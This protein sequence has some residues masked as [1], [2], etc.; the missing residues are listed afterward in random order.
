MGEMNSQYSPNSVTPA[1]AGVQDIKMDSRL[2]GDCKDAEGRATH[3]AVAGNDG[4]AVLFVLCLALLS[5][6]TNAAEQLVTFVSCP[7]YRDTDAGR[8]SGCWLAD[9]H[10]SGKRFDIADAP[11]KPI[12]GRE[13]LI[14]GIVAGKPDT[15]GGVMLNPVRVSVLP[16]TCPS[17]ML[18]A[19]AFPG[20]A[21]VLPSTT[22]APTYAV[23]TPPAPPFSDQSYTIF[24]A[25]N[26]D[27]LMYQHSEVLLDAA[28]QYI[29]A[30]KP[31]R[32]VITAYAATKPIKVSGR[33]IV[34]SIYIAKARAA[35]IVEALTRLNVP[36]A[37]I[38]VETRGD[39]APDGELAKQGLSEAS[40]RRAVVR[41]EM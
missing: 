21:F 12:L 3:G 27:F 19:E 11:I 9:D 28:V 20:R 38:K 32:V 22:L 16:T 15:C 2:R 18:P 23:R 25:L 39:P 7:I 33:E 35:M 17:F 31:K 14:E 1:Q 13:I 30:A 29:E 26:S 6:R 10:D 41:L 8:K 40:K 34:E 24:F 4:R 37:M 36:S 5:A